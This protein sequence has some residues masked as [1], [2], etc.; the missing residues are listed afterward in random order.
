M[1]PIKYVDRLN[2]KYRSLGFPAYEW[3]IHRDASISPLQKPLRDCRVSILTTSGASRKQDPG[4]DPDARNDLRLDAIPADTPSDGFDINDNYYDH[5]S[6]VEDINC[7]FPI[8]RLRELAAD[9]TIGQSAPRHWSGFMGRIYKRSA[10]IAK[11]EEFAEALRQDQVDLLIVVPACPLDHQ[12]AGLVART[13]EETGIATVTVST[14]RDLSVQVLAPRTVFVN[15]PMGNAFGRPGDTNQ[16]RQILMDALTLASTAST[17]GE[18][19]DLPYDWG[20]E[21]AVH[22]R[23]TTREFQLKK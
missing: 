22:Y 21:I 15:F 9:G 10:I 5:R 13:V 14:G 16:Q 11:A 4:F 8:E 6:V 17:A 18:L 12:T 1:E 3:T 7:Q 20:S 19:I 2:E 23:E